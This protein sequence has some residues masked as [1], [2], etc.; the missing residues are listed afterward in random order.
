MDAQPDSPALQHF[1]KQGPLFIWLVVGNLFIM[2]MSWE[3]LYQHYSDVETFR[4]PLPPP[5]DYPN[6]ATTPDTKQWNFSKTPTYRYLVDAGHVKPI[7]FKIENGKKVYNRFAGVNKP[8][9]LI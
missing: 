8:M 3:Y 6:P 1:K 2:Y 4:K 5:L 7:S 9:E